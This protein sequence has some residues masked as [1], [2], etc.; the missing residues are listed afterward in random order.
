[1]FTSQA[2]IRRRK[3]ALSVTVSESVNFLKWREAPPP[4]P[5]PSPRRDNDLVNPPVLAVTCWSF[6]LHELIS[7][8]M[9]ISNSVM[10]SQIVDLT[11]VLSLDT[12]VR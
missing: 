2:D 3:L 5:T 10:I 11:M 6:T 1:M 8:L 4:P 9:C 12:T 7:D